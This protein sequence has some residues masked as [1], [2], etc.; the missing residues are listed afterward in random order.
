MKITN[1][2]YTNFFSSNYKPTTETYN[3]K[4]S[5]SK[6]E[7]G[8][9][10]NLSAWNYNESIN[11][12]LPRWDL[13]RIPLKYY[14]ENTCK[15]GKFLPQF[16]NI[17]DNC[18]LAWM[19]ASYGLIRFQRLYNKDLADITISWTDIITNGREYEAGN[20]NLKVIGHKIDKAEINIVI[21]P[22][23][24]KGLSVSS[25]IER[26]RRTALHEIGHALGLNHSQDSKDMMFHRGINNKTLSPND[27]KRLNE[28]YNN[29]NPKVIS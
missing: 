29:A 17:T 14:I 1:S 13:G 27:V 11:D 21:F 22:E 2:A 10:N 16:V 28:L 8:S 23:I 25:R 26:V 12:K 3:M 20:N 19:R 24:D 9:V 4:P 15:D 5:S 18:I 7:N 6:V